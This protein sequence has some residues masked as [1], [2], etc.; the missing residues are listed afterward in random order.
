MKNLP[1][2]LLDLYSPLLV[3]ENVSQSDQ[4]DYLKGLRFSLDFYDKYKCQPR[5]PEICLY[6]LREA[7]G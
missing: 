2:A 5:S 7:A 6:F 4:R 3:V 1:K